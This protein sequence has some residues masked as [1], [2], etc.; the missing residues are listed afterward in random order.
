VD[1]LRRLQLE[2][3]ERALQ[4]LGA[5]ARGLSQR[6]GK[7]SAE[8]QIEAAGMYVDPEQSRSFWLALVHVIRNA[9]DHGFE[10]PEARHG[11]GKPIE[12]QLRLE[13]SREADRVTLRISDDGRGVD[14]E[15]VRTLA[16]QRGLP[17]QTR[18]ELV[19]ALLAPEVSTRS[20]VTHTS[21]RGVGLAAVEQDIRALE[22]TLDVESEPGRGC[23][24]I[25]SVPAARLGAL[26]PAPASERRPIHSNRPSR[27]A[28]GE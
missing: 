6:L 9:V 2:P 12:N 14:W 24:W 7:G 23:T 25:I 15:R 20:E 26:A 11:A 5:H 13:A 3:I 28:A 16:A 19:R 27:A 8:V 1:E 21:G 17:H 22:G 18:A 10:G 4:R